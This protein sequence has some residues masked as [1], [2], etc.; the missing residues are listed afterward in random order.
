MD[1]ADW[2]SLIALA[3]VAILVVPGALRRNRGT[4]LRNAAIWLAVVVALVWAYDRFGPF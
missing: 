3:M 1:T 4:A 2:M